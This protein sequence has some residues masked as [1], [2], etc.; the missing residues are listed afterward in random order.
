MPTLGGQL[1]ALLRKQGLASR[2]DRKSLFIQLFVPV[3]LVGIS[4]A[5][6]FINNVDTGSSLDPVNLGID[7][8]SY[9]SKNHPYNSS[10]PVSWEDTGCRTPTATAAEQ[11][12]AAVS[13]ETDATYTVAALQQLMVD[14]DYA[15]I[16]NLY[17]G[18]VGPINAL[19]NENLN[20][21]DNVLH[22]NP[23]VG[24]A[25][26]ACDNVTFNSD[27]VRLFFVRFHF[28]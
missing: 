21:T 6:Q 5:F 13:A 10:F 1:R 9:V 23:A 7:T 27:L 18:G 26:V 12:L 24:A 3:M 17:P 14:V 28:V 11:L 22:G 4:Y 19:L 16:P 15:P 25:I 20:R 8:L 2:R